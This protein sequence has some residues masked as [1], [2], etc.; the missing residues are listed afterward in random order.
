MSG[1]T[2]VSLEWKILEYRRYTSICYFKYRVYDEVCVNLDGR[3]LFRFSPR[4]FAIT[5]S[6]EHSLL[7]VAVTTTH[8]LT[9]HA[10]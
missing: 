10:L 8:S 3:C 5:L 7:N 6:I 9:I 1:A 4:H 2:G